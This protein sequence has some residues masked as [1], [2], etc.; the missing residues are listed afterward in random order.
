MSDKLPDDV[1]LKVD[2]VVGDSIC[3]CIS[4]Y[5]LYT[6]Q[7]CPTEWR[8]ESGVFVRSCTNDR[9]VIFKEIGESDGR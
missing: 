1:V 4:C 7:R 6:E 5:F 9:D 8:K 2:D 3:S